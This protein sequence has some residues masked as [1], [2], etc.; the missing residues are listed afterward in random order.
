[1]RRVRVRDPDGTVREG[2]LVER[3]VVTDDERYDIENVEFLPPVEPSKL[4]CTARN[5]R[6]GIGDPSEIPESPI[7]FLKAPNAV[8]GPGTRVE[9]PGRERVLFEGELG[10]VIGER[11]RNVPEESA[12]DVVDG[13][14][15][16]NDITNREVE[17]IVR[18]KSFDDAAPIGPAVVS[19]GHVP[20]DATIEVR[21]NDEINQK[22]SLS[23]LIFDVPELVASISADLTLEPGDVIL[24]GSPPGM[25]PLRDGDCV[26]IG[27]EGVG[28]LV[29]GVTVP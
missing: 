12:M 11:C 15:C 9:L 10:V 28:T 6:G 22:S 29:H 14:T 13:F 5:Y 1:M 16:A 20:D 17:N 18:R 8:T 27:I 21:V 24:T 3:T 25:A 26:E 7:L 19:P 4:V 23:R 2:E